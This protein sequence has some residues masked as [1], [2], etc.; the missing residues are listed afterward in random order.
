MNAI[1]VDIGGTATRVGLVVSVG[2]GATDATLAV[3]EHFQ[4]GPDFATLQQAIAEGVTT[5]CS[6]SGLSESQSLPVGLAIPGLVN[7]ASSLVRRCVNLPFI[8]EH[9]PVEL[10]P[11]SLRADSHV[12]SDAEAATWGEY[13]ACGNLPKRFAHLRFGTGV[14]CGVI[15]AGAMVDLKRPIDQHAD[16]LVIDGSV[17]AVL[18]KCGRRGCLET[19]ASRD[20]LCDFSRDC[21]FGGTLAELG[22]FVSEGDSRAVKLV[23]KVAGGIAVVASRLAEEYGVEVLALGGGVVAALPQVLESVS[24][25]LGHAGTVRVEGGVMGDEAGVVGAGAA[26]LV[27]GA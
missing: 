4:T 24:R 10:L 13:Y 25:H 20:A 6:R 9:N 15:V 16:V 8:E 14:A 7:V 2:D 17:G 18:C 21:G 1:G 12:M 22:R 3:V 27:R 23:D 19:I 11:E 5:V 26:A